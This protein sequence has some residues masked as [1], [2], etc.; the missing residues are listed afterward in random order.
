M[1][2]SS[3]KK[4]ARRRRS[5][6]VELSDDFN[7]GSSLRYT[8]R[9]MYQSL[10]SLLEPHDISIG[11]FY[12]LITL[13]KGDGLTQRELAERVGIMGPGTV[14]QLRRMEKRGLIKRTPSVTD[15]RKIHVFL[16][17]KG[18][19]LKNELLPLARKSN[20][21]ALLGFSPAETRMLRQYLARIR[22]NMS[23]AKA[24]NKAAA[25]MDA[26]FE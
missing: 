18:R 1:S 16:T 11:T 21:I 10:Q 3:R 6:D 24:D 9:F 2:S 22:A 26:S 8:F 15:R 7:I 25:R 17:P 14:E 19:K 12:F 13:W 4:P 5:S 20:A 23:A